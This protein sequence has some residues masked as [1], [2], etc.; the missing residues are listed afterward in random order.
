[1]SRR[2]RIACALAMMLC[3]A[4]AGAQVLTTAD[5]LGKGKTGLLFSDNVL[6]PGDEGVP[7]LNIA[8]AMIA[9]GA[10]NRLDVYLSAG[11][12]TTKRDPT[13][14]RE[15]QAWIGGG[16]NVHLFKAGTVSVSLFDVATVPLQR[17]DEACDVLLNSALVASVP[18]GPKFSAYSGINALIPIGHR[19]RGIFTPPQTEVNV[20]VGGTYAVG[21]WGIWAEVDIGHLRAVGIGVTR[22][23]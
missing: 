2:R 16:G 13:A 5:T 6:V 23:F 14:R 15:T 1:M 10:T 22:V 21:V 19:E 12:T 20:P 7:N 18:I 3:A 17:R 9:I 11:E 8:Y 4:P